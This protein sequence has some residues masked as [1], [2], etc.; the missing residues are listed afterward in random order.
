MTVDGIV[1]VH[2]QLNAKGI[3]SIGKRIS[4]NCDSRP[5]RKTKRSS[6]TE[7]VIP[8]ACF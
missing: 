8:V 7:K 3:N 2:G 4:A 6:Q 1:Y 5:E